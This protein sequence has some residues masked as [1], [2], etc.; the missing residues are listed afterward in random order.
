M[1]LMTKAL[2]ARFAKVGRQ[3]ALGE[4]AVVIAKFFHPMSSWT[5]YATEFDEAT[6]TFFGLVDGHEE[7]LGY[8][9]LT[10]M[11]EV[12][13]RGLG[14]ERDL[15]WTEKPLRACRKAAVR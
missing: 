2:E 6:Q 4:D 11:A 5:W 7:E 8:F 9:S 13:V 10:E 12:K 3:E 1:K 14:V 15:Y